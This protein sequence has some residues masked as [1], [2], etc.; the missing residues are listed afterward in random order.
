MMSYS[1]FQEMLKSIPANARKVFDIIPIGEGWSYSQIH[2][3]VQRIG[4]NVRAEVVMGCVATLKDAGLVFEP[5]QSRF[6]RAPHKPKP[7]LRETIT[8]QKEPPVANPPSAAIH[9]IQTRPATA[10]EKLSATDKLGA[11]SA[12][13]RMLAEGAEKLASTA[14]G[15]ADDMDDIALA[16]EEQAGNIGEEMQKLRNLASALKALGG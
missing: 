2:Q 14:R 4:M 12:Q 1:R 7:D 3:E 16:I 8:I 10:E 5:E 6:Q 13:V 9:P 11:L 15:I